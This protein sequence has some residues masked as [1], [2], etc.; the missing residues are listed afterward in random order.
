MPK[1]AV[2]GTLKHGHCN[3]DL[4]IECKLVGALWIEGYTMH[5]LGAYPAVTRENYLVNFEGPTPDIWCEVYEVSDDITQI[6]LDRLEGYPHLYQKEVV[7]TIIGDVT[8]YT[9]Q[10]AEEH[11]RITN[12]EW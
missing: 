9:M 7:N 10:G 1:V 3:H 4:L 11:E 5:S 2:Y 8:L 6:R 12:G